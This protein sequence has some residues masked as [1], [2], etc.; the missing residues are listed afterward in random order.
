MYPITLLLLFFIIIIC[1]Y[2][3]LNK[4]LHKFA[5]KSSAKLSVRFALLFWQIYAIICFVYRRGNFLYVLRCFFGLIH[6]IRKF[7]IY[8]ALVFSTISNHI[9]DPY[10]YWEIS[11]VIYRTKCNLNWPKKHE[12]KLK[13]MFFSKGAS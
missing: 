5:K 4:L 7:P 11:Y 13:I 9:F 12:E 8:F 3:F 6:A 2:Y 1:Y 10:I